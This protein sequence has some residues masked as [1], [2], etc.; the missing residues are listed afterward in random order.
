MGTCLAG[1]QESRAGGRDQDGRPLDASGITCGVRV[2][3]TM[4]ERTAP[5]LSAWHYTDPGA[6]P[7]LVTAYPTTYNRAYGSN[8]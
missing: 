5:M 8:A 4:G 7:R 1:P 3:L 6:A 2:E